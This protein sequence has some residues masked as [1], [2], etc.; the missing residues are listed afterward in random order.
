[1]RVPSPEAEDRRQLHRELEVLKEE[2]KRHRVR[3]QSLLFTQGIDVSV[4]RDFLRKL[5]QFRCWNQQPVPPQMKRR[6]EDEYHRLQLVEAQIRENQKTRAEQVK[7]ATNDA[8]VEKVLKLH[9]LVS[10]GLAARGRN[11]FS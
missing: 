3:V 11:H 8:V 1:V 4:G 9:R 5:E 2:R 10:I 6:I 7:L